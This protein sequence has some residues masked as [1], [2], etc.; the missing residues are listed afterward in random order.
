MKMKSA[1]SF[2]FL[3]LTLTIIASSYK[4]GNNGLIQGNIPQDTLVRYRDGVYTG[5][6]RSTYTD[7]PYWGIVK[8]KIKDGSL[9]YVS[10]RVR[11][12]VLHED[13]DGAYEKHFEGNQVYI[14]QSRNDWKGVQEYPKK[15]MVSKN[16]Q[17]VDAVS[18]ATW[19]Y[20]IFRDAFGEAIK[21]AVV[22]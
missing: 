4:A 1:I 10:F 18:G 13:F 19:S 7:E 12:S 5:M 21:N 2:T 15:L 17:K 22:R 20:N 11:D 3:A 8:I 14:E 6:S 9:T 16:I